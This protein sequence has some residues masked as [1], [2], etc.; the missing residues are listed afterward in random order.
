MWYATIFFCFLTPN[1]PSCLVAD[2]VRG[3]YVT[4]ARCDERTKEMALAIINRFPST[5]VQSLCQ[6]PDGITL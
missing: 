5:L 1:G 2:D 4:E 3:P 6:G